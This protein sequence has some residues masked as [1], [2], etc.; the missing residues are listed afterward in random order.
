MLYHSALNGNN[1]YHSNRIGTVRRQHA[2]HTCC[3][4]MTTVGWRLFARALT[5]LLA[6]NPMTM[7]LHVPII[8]PK[9]RSPV[10]KRGTAETDDCPRFRSC[11]APAPLQ[12]T[13]QS[14]HADSCETSAAQQNLVLLRNSPP[15]RRKR[16]S[17]GTPSLN[18]SLPTDRILCSVDSVG[19]LVRYLPYCYRIP[20]YGNSCLIMNR[21]RNPSV[22]SQVNNNERDHV[23][24]MFYRYPPVPS[25]TSAQRDYFRQR[26][27]IGKVEK[28]YW[29]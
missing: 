21:F 22:I 7:V 29:I 20:C 27:F 28:R 2:R 15:I 10:R 18:S 19:Y 3:H 11:A 24:W 25:A 23:C 13:H 9:C 16:K 17:Q 1:R 26:N 8:L 14:N 6:P 4:S 5:L 12:L